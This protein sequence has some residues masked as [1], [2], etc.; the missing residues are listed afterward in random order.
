MYNV[1]LIVYNDIKDN[2]IKDN[3]IYNTLTKCETYTCPICMS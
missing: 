1:I 3:H 2:H